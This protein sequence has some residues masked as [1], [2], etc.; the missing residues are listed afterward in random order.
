MSSPRREELKAI[1]AQLFAARSFAAVT[2]DDIGAA[3]GVSG[4]ALYHHFASKEALLGE[5]LV[6]IS[7][8]LLAEAEAITSQCRPADALPALVAAHVDFALDR[9]DLITVQ[10]RDLVYAGPADQEA[11]RRLQSR[12]VDLWVQELDG[13]GSR[14]DRARARATVHSV[15]GMLNSTPHS[16][17]LE[18]SAMATLLVELAM[19]ALAAS[20]PE[21]RRVSDATRPSETRSVVAGVRSR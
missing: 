9:Q 13:L 1:A 21:S 3:A 4:P 17:R 7:E 12:Y 14:H 19:A 10:Y 18:R 6:S 11:V 2:M 15:L 16:A 20:R 8:H 5:M